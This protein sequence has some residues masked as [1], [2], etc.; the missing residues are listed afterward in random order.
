MDEKTKELTSVLSA[1]YYNR[2]ALFRHSFNQSTP[3]SVE[4]A[5]EQEALAL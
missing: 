3:C 5:I 4:L 1:L 2:R